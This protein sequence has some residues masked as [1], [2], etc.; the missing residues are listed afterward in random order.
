MASLNDKQWAKARRKWEEDPREGFQWLI[1]ELKLEIPRKTIDN[2]ARRH[3]WTKRPY[4]PQ[5]VPEGTQV[6]IKDLAQ[7]SSLG[8]PTLY[9]KEYA[10]QA[11]KLCL[12]GLTDEELAK[13]FEVNV[14]TINE[15]KHKHA[16][17]SE[18]L[19]KGKAIADGNVAYALYQRAIGYEHADVH[20][21]VINEK[22]VL[23][24]LIKYYPPD[25]T[26]I[27]FWL[28]N[29]QPEKWRLKVE[30]EQTI[31]DPF[32][33]K[34]KLNE[35]RAKQ[36]NR[37]KELEEKRKKQRETLG[38]DISGLLDNSENE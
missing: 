26:A 35:I 10:K 12:L 16:E 4:V 9:K 15:W 1:D 27:K 5:K 30:V 28:N 33:D 18:S 22:V 31:I 29:R 34:E 6:S 14:S 37:A 11:Y 36:L 24:P 19:K 3:Q 13:F 23:T 17:F 38:L 8:R 21:A 7:E 25:P 2:H 20:V 32:P